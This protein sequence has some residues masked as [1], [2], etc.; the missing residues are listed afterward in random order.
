MEIIE[1]SSEEYAQAFD[2]PYHIYNSAPFNRLNAYKAAQVYYLAFRDTK[3]RLGLIAGACE[4]QLLSPFSAPFGGFQYLQADVKIAHIEESIARLDEWA[5]NKGLHTIQIVLPPDIY[6]ES[7]I[8]KQFNSLLRSGYQLAYADINYAFPLS[9]LN[10]HYLDS[11]WHNARK[12]YKKALSYGLEFLQLSFDK[13]EDAYGIIVANRAAKGYPLRM[14]LHQVLDTTRIVPMDGFVVKFENTY[15]AAAI[16]SHVTHQIV[17]VVY[18]G[19]LPGF[20]EYKPINFLA[21]Q[22]FNF[23]QAKGLQ[24]VDIGPSSENGTPNYGLCEFKESIGC[25]MSNKFT[26][27][28]KLTNHF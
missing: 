26:L 11:I 24:M 15:I 20:S 14:T 9:K 7:F 22:L 27:I 21:Y 19:D 17:Q 2:K 1:L 5:M 4:G 28:R 3:L 8:V 23:Y 6:H 13:L 12:N 10:E 25:M 16:V 18:W